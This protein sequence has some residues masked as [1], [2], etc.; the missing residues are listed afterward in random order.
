MA[1]RLNFAGRAN[2]DFEKQTPDP[3]WVDMGGDQENGV[4]DEGKN[5]FEYLITERGF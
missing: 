4:Y 1:L 2:G 5:V 3:E